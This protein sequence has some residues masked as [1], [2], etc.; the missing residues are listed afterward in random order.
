MVQQQLT[1]YL[2][3]MKHCCANLPLATCTA[4]CM[5]KFCWMLIDQPGAFSL[6]ACYHLVATSTTAFQVSG[7]DAVSMHLRSTEGLGLNEADILKAT[8]KVILYAPPKIDSLAKKKQLA[9]FGTLCGAIFGKK[10]GLA[11]GDGQMDHSHN[12]I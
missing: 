8:T 9:V 12:K 5:G 6:L 3:D 11:T 1:R 7:E 2:N 10:I 4:I